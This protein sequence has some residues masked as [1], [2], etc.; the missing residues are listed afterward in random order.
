MNLHQMQSFCWTK[1]FSAVRIKFLVQSN[2]CDFGKLDE[3]FTF[4]IQARVAKMK[5]TLMNKIRV[6]QLEF[7]N[8]RGGCPDVTLANHA[9]KVIESKESRS[10]PA[11]YVG[12]I[13]GQKFP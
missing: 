13:S 3:N 4:E 1:Y 12:S 11:I 8:F 6:I 10:E 5:G 9:K 7:P 2:I